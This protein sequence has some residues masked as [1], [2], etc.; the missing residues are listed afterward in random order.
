MVRKMNVLVVTNMYPTENS[1]CYGSFVQEQVE[2]L[3]KQGIHVDVYFINGR[4]N[5]LNYFR[6]IGRLAKILRKT[7][8][9]IIHAH[10]SYCVYPIMI[11][12]LIAGRK[13]PLL[14]TFHE[15]ELHWANQKSHREGDVL[16]RLVFSRKIKSIALRMSDFVIAVEDELLTELG[17]RGKSAVVPCGVNVEL[18]R[19]LDR[20]AC[21]ES[22]NLPQ[23]KRIVF[24][25][26]SPEN[27]QKGFDIL[28]G[29][30]ENLGRNDVLVVTA[31][32]IRHEEMPLYMNAADVVVQLSVFEASPAVV[33]EAMATN[34]PLVFTDTGDAKKIIDGVE[35]CYLCER[36]SESVVEVL[37]E[38]LSFEGKCNGRER[39]LE[40]EVTLEGISKKIIQ[41]YENLVES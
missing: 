38:A 39:I 29:A 33:K 31:G 12:K 16:K 23:D 30:V 27:K 14:L 28:K 7:R 1:V 26:A 5:R 3:I 22:L 41:V 25:P 6:S 24:F 40:E 10:H 17:F 35:G 20:K 34:T 2:S 11:A 32:N 37:R 9:D 4:E 36:K 8:C 21:R 18:F 19:P 13:C 15:G